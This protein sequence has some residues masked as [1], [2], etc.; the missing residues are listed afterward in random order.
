MKKITAFISALLICALAIIPMLAISTSAATEPQFYEWDFEEALSYE[1]GD[2]SIPASS[3]NNEMYYIKSTSYRAP[4]DSFKQ[5]FHTSLGDLYCNG[6]YFELDTPIAL[7]ANKSWA[8]EISGTIPNFTKLLAEK[9]NYG[10]YIQ[11]NPQYPIMNGN[12]LQSDFNTSENGRLGQTYVQTIRIWNEYNTSANKWEIHF[13]VKGITGESRGEGSYVVT[14]PKGTANGSLGF[15]VS[16]IGSNDSPFQPNNVLSGGKTVYNNMYLSS[17][18]IWEDVAAGK[19]IE[20]LGDEIFKEPLAGGVRRNYI[21]LEEDIAST[22]GVTW[23]DEN[24]QSFIKFE[25]GKTYTATANLRPGF[26]FNFKSGVTKIPNGYNC[27]FNNGGTITVS[28]TF[29]VTKS[30]DEMF[31][32]EDSKTPEFSDDPDVTTPGDDVTTPNGDTGDVTTPNGDTGDVT[33]PGDTD[34]VITPGGCQGAI[35]S[36]TVMIFVAAAA[37]VAIKKKK[38]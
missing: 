23:V 9:K 24:G 17:L 10:K 32:T 4:N 7:D 26:G 21:Y 14:S 34:E 36:G 5:G 1:D 29:V 28:K 6:G 25:M 11:F 30:L 22:D 35:V 2:I 3:G 37:A 33:T 27:V 16:Y 12:N 13:S 19:T 20:D 8:V 38:D 31:I 15:T 18:K